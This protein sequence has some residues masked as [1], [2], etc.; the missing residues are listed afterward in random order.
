MSIRPEKEAQIEITTRRS[1]L[2]RQRKFFPR[3]ELLRTLLRLLEF[4]NNSDRGLSVLLTDDAEIKRLNRD[5][6]GK[7]R[8]TD[9][10]S[11]SLD[12]GEGAPVVE[13]AP[14][15]DL[16]VSVPTILRQARAHSLS[17][18]DEMQRMLVHGLLHLLG[19]E[20]EGVSS[21]RARKMRLE[22]KRL[23]ELLRAS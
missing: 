9:V 5:F 8:P 23:L 4:T 3:R 1:V 21:S 6:R 17:P 11:F 16:V 20:H 13:L 7:D 10:L 14:L 12:E 19:Y 22:E 18:K 15:G 2:V